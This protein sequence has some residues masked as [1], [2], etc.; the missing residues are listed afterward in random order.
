MKTLKPFVRL[1]EIITFWK[2]Y[3]EKDVASFWLLFWRQQTSWNSWR[4]WCTVSGIQKICFRLGFL[5]VFMKLI[6]MPLKV[7]GIFS[8]SIELRYSYITN[9]ILRIKFYWLVGT[10]QLK[11]Y[12]LRQKKVHKITIGYIKFSCRWLWCQKPFLQGLLICVCWWINY[13]FQKPVIFQFNACWNYSHR[14]VSQGEGSCFRVGRRKLTRYE[15][16]RWS[17]GKEDGQSRPLA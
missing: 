2:L 14:P 17:S 16:R 1:I 7:I 12:V 3:L 4:F 11:N 6:Y 9:L 8:S 15:K 5:I 10:L 13:S